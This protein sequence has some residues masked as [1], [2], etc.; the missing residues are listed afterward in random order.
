MTPND[1]PPTDG[2]PT[3]DPEPDP[4]GPPAPD[5]ALPP[6]QVS[7]APDNECM[8]TPANDNAIPQ[9]ANDNA[10]YGPANDNASVMPAAN[11]VPA[12]ITPEQEL[13]PTGTDG[14]AG[15]QAG[16]RA[17]E[18]RNMAGGGNR[19]GGRRS[20]G[21]DD[22]NGGY[23]VG[24]N[25]RTPDRKVRTEDE[26]EQNTSSAQ[27]V[28]LRDFFMSNIRG[29]MA[30]AGKD[31]PED[32]NGIWDRYT[33]FARD[34]QDGHFHLDAVEAMQSLENFVASEL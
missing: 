29:V 2:E 24:G 25:R 23:R 33:L 17:P 18:I 16:G 12:E 3:P 34:H 22:E 13:A 31:A 9:A 4:E 21:G 28:N 14:P 20:R 11:D 15:P 10:S 32:L 8:C 19:G 30:R 26:A 5:E 6:E 27:T 7:D 1:P